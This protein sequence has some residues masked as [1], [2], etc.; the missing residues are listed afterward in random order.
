MPPLLS[1]FFP[2]RGGHEAACKMLSLYKLAASP[3]WAASSPDMGGIKKKN[4]QCHL[5]TSFLTPRGSLSALHTGAA[6]Q[7]L[8][9]LRTI[10]RNSGH[11][12]WLSRCQ[13][14]SSSTLLAPPWPGAQVAWPTT[15]AY[16][17]INN[18]PCHRS[19]QHF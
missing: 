17:G 8:Q 3:S 13:C 11:K 10:G 19:Y 5:A 14:D 4:H 6:L 18:L 9:T 2:Q 16:A 1:H 12:V 7:I 15:P